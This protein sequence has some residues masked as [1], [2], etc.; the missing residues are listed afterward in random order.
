MN[1]AFKK[2]K[3]WFFAV[4]LQAMPKI[5]IPTIAGY[6]LAFPSLT[7]DTML[8]LAVLVFL[9]IFSQWFIVLMNDFADK[10]ADAYHLRFHPK[11][12]ERRVLPEGLLSSTQVLVSGLISGGLVIVAA[13]VLLKMGRSQILPLSLLGLFLLWAYSF[14][15]IKLNYRGGGEFLEIIGTGVILPFA[16][17]FVALPIWNFNQAH[18]LLPILIYAIISSFASGLKHEPADRENGKKT[19]CVLF[20]SSFVRRVIWALQILS[21]IWCGLLFL[22]GDY[23]L[24]A[25]IFSA[26]VPAIPMFNTRRY[27]NKADFQDLEALSSYKKSLQQSGILTQFGL[28]VDFIMG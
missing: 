16:G 14:P 18:Y 2:V 5:I 13:V 7:S 25:M 24:Y 20:G 3:K 22:S 21:R 15:P 27:E 1:E 6:V 8:H 23:G 28:I 4:K 17:A 19:I 26:I 12:I 9:L 10:D 11:L